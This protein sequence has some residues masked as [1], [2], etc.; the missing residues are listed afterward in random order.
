MSENN[1]KECEHDFIFQGMTYK[2]GSYS[3]PGTS[4]K[5]VSYYETFYCKK[6]LKKKHLPVNCQRTTYDEILFGATPQ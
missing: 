1:Q 5:S 6:C 3:L 2:R 4:A